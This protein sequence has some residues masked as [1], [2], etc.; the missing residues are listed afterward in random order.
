MLQ[1]TATSLLAVCALTKAYGGRVIVDGLD[2][3]VGAGSAVALMGPNGCGKSTV[4]RCLSGHEQ[5]TFTSFETAGSPA[6]VHSSAYRRD[7]FPIFDDFSFFPDITVAE[8]LELLAGMYGVPDHEATAA[9]ALARFGVSGVAQQFPASLSSGQIRRVAFAAAAIRPWKLLLLDE[10]EQRLDAGGRSRL[11]QFLQEQLAAG[12]GLVL[13][14]HDAGLTQ[15]L[16]AR[17]VTLAHQG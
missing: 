3:E 8:H 7:I 11:V 12:R 2:L 5:G 17:V 1:G 16:G 6:K 9:A 10:P 13:A 14:T 4:L 15:L